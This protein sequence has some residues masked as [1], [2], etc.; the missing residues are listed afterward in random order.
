MFIK[1]YIDE[2]YSEMN[3][4][5]FKP[6]LILFPKRFCLHVKMGFAK[7]NCR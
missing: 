5:L 4:V 6:I 2:R 1:V 3:N 7:R